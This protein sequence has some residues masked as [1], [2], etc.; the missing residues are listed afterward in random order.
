MANA[1]AADGRESRAF[2]FF[3][4][5]I[6]VHVGIWLFKMLGAHGGQIPAIL[7]ML[8]AIG[9]GFR[10]LFGR[11]GDR[12]RRPWTVALCWAGLCAGLMALPWR[13]GVVKRLLGGDPPGWLLIVFGMAVSAVILTAIW[14]AGN[15]ARYAL[16]GLFMLQFTVRNCADIIRYPQR[17]FDVIQWH[18]QASEMLR[19]GKNPYLGPFKIYA[20]PEAAAGIYSPEVLDGDTVLFGFPYPPL[21]LLTGW[22]GYLL[23]GE[24]RMAMVGAYLLIA[25]L[26]YRLLPTRTGLV[27]A[28]SILTSPTTAHILFFC[29]T[30][31]FC[32]L[33]LVLAVSTYLWK[34]RWT[35][36]AF[37]AL[38]SVKQTMLLLLPVTWLLFRAFPPREGLVRW[39]GKAAL[40]I[41]V[42]VL[43]F[44]LWSPREF[45]FSVGLIQVMQPFRQ[46]SIS[47][48]P[49]LFPNTA[50]GKSLAGVMSMTAFGAVMAWGWYWDVIRGGLAHWAALA[51]L[52]LASLFIFNK[53]AFSNYYFFC[54][55]LWLVSALLLLR[56]DEAS[57]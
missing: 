14:R 18:Q 57:D 13:A 17:D 19:E 2:W 38:L 33:Y 26:C 25:I 45:V 11:G 34:P 42:L 1:V 50:A 22:P 35:A 53:Q 31:T 12:W 36:I 5:A 43:P 44:V 3:L 41:A 55:M 37:G 16:L 6:L 10:G 52:A 39:A 40:F 54:A 8:G 9:A 7:C 21:S 27:I 20:N 29:W 51:A 47:F 32:V 23:F 46:D 24:Y 56:E 30:E 4:A 28:A 15:R 48:A 49:L